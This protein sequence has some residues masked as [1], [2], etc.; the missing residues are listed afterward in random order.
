MLYWRNSRNL[1]FHAIVTGFTEFLSGLG[2]MKTSFTWTVT[3][4][5]YILGITWNDSLRKEFYDQKL[6]L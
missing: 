4:F 2:I 3:S 1:D 6:K 5:V